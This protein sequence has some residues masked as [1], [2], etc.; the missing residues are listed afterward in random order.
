V[1]FHER[2]SAHVT[3]GQVRVQE[4]AGLI[5]GAGAEVGGAGGVGAGAVGEASAPVEG[6]LAQAVERAEAA[7]AALAAAVGLARVAEGVP[8]RAAEGAADGAARRQFLF[9]QWTTHAVEHLP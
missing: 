7:V 9:K 5:E 8:V 6:G 1:S 3:D 4:L 2:G